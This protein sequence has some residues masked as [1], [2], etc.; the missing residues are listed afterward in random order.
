MNGGRSPA[1]SGNLSLRA[2][3][4]SRASRPAAVS[5]GKSGMWTSSRPWR[6]RSTSRRS[7]PRRRKDPDD[8][9]AVARVRHLLGEHGVDASGQTAV[10]I[11]TL[12]LAGR[13]IGFVDEDDDLSERV[14]DGE[15]LLQ[16]RLGRADPAIAEVLEDDA[17]MPSSP[18]QHCTRKV[19]PV[20]M[21]PADQISHRQ[22][23]QRA[24]SQQLGVLAQ[25]A[26][27]ASCPAT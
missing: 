4:S 13:L 15:D 10:A 25:P 2:M 3:A 12:A 9:A 24:T 21:R 26:L 17:G 7:G 19:L 20:P 5:G 11:A 8:A 1:A 23:A 16:V 6:F 27:T 14:Q 18:A 22:R